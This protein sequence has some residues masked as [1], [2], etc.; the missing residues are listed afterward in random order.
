MHADYGYFEEQELGK[1]YDLKLLKRLWFFMKPYQRWLW[2]SVFLLMLMTLVEL[3]I[4]YLTRIAIDDY[5]VPKGQ[6]YHSVEEKLSGITRISVLFLILII[7]DFIFNFIQVM[8]VEYAGQMMMHDLRLN[9][10]SHLQSLSLSFFNHNP[11][12]RLVTRVTNDVQNMNEL[13]T[14]VTVFMFKDMIMLVGIAIMLLALNWQLA[15][16]SFMVIP[17]VYIASIR[18]SGKARELFRKLRLLVAKINIRFSETIA[19]IKIIQLFMQEMENYRNFETLNHENYTTMLSQISVYAIFM[20]IIGFLGTFVMALVIFYGGVGVLAESITLGVLVAFLSYVRMFFRPIQDIA[21]KHNILQNAMASAERIFLILDNDEKLPQPADSPVLDR[22]ESIEVKDICFAYTPG[23]PVLNNV[24]F[25]VKAGETV[26]IVGPT[27]SGKTSVIH[28][29]IRFYEPN[30]GQILVNGYDMKSLS[31]SALRDKT[32]LVSQDP[33]LFSE[34]VFHNIF[35]DRA[36][37]SEDEIEAVLRDSN[38]KEIIQKL[39]KGIHSELSEGGASVS[40]GE[41][42][43]ISIA[44]AF[45][46]NPDLI[47]LDEATSY[48]DSETEA[49]IQEALSNLT[50]NRTTLIIAHRLSTVR[51]AD[52]IIVLRRGRIIEIG[53]H[54]ELMKQKGFYFKLNQ[55]QH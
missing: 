22:I 12:G 9:I 36:D 39:P 5:I 10:F 3:A 6:V 34:S 44:R 26:A 25:S 48:I 37:V 53:T 47:I 29:L 2:L 19:G 27:G 31:P 49:K 41:R 30:S 13:F 32:A 51:Q 38:C 40:S 17:V 46:R 24:S 45:A 1:S 7:L 28:L 4:P 20:R 35:Q 42:Q 54:E 21:E 16:V 50:R 14:S 18:F 55:M 15:V 23:E 52:R 8:V 33:F 11:V 43:L